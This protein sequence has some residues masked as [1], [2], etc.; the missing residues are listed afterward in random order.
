MAKK[1]VSRPVS[2]S[3]IRISLSR[4][5]LRRLLHLVYI[6][7]WVLSA[8]KTEADPRAAP[9]D[10]LEQKLYAVAA[11]HGFAGET[12]NPADDL[13]DYVEEF[14]Q[15]FPTLDFE[16]GEVHEFLD[17]YDDDTFW[18]ELV[19]RLAERDAAREAGGF[20]PYAGLPWTE[21]VERTSHFEAIYADEFYENGLDNV[22]IVRPPASRHTV[23]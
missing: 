13:L 18:D 2:R 23:H 4:D 9:Y 12:G 16:E 1:P 14:K 21:R 15:Y 19:Y 6:G 7:T 20:E 8:H 3:E 11:R 17:E 22:R 5:E 10:A